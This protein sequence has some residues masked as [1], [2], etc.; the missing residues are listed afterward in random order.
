MT[1]INIELDNV[2]QEAINM[3][4][5]VIS[6]IEKTQDAVLTFNKDLASEVVAHEKRVNALEL[7]IDYDCENIIALFNPVAIDLRFILALL[8]INANLER[9]GDIAQGLSKF[10]VKSERPFDDELL[11]T[12]HIAMMFN[13]AVQMLKTVCES[14]EKEDTILARS[15]F[16]KDIILDDINKSISN[17]IT[18]YI[19]DNPENVEQGLQALSM[20]RKIERIGDQCKNIAEEIIF[21][22]EAKVLRHKKLSKKTAQLPDSAD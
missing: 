4:H 5:L 2:K 16:V 7:K 20:V 3:W 10:L 8:K 1:H 22:I 17:A 19:H 15:I 12:A 9:L 21:Y 11:K 18:K 13:T 6:Q 14:F